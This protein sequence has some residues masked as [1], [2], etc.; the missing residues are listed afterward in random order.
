[1]DTDFTERDREKIVPVVFL[2][3]EYFALLAREPDL[4]PVLALGPRL[5]VGWKGKFYEVK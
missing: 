4:A 3:E 2:S 5:L 1:M